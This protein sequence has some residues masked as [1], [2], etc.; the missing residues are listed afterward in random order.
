MIPAN[1]EKEVGPAGASYHTVHTTMVRGRNGFERLSRSA[2]IGVFLSTTAI[3][4]FSCL[5]LESTVWRESRAAEA[6]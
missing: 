1:G 2:A 5:V 6:A 4:G 3:L